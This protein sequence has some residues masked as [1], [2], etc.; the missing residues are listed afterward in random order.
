[1]IGSNIE[2][3]NNNISYFV[4]CFR[5]VERV[6]NIFNKKII[7]GSK[8]TI[9]KIID[10]KHIP[11]QNTKY[12]FWLEKDGQQVKVWTRNTYAKEYKIGDYKKIVYVK[13]KYYFEDENIISEL[14][15]VIFFVVLALLLLI[16]KF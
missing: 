9:C 11:G 4:D 12:T 2:N 5:G 13:K 7:K 10:L 3:G 1:M 6:S 8:R 15:G 14:I 16:S